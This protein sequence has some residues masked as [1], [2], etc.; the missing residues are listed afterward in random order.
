MSLYVICKRH[1]ETEL[2]E[3]NASH[4]TFLIEKNN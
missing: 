4:M 2:S 3:I 1:S